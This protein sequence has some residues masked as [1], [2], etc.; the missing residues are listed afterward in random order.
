MFRIAGAGGCVTRKHFVDSP[1]IIG[2]KFEVEGS[3]ILFQILA[4]LSARNRHNV[5]T[6]REHPC[7]RQLRRLAALFLCNFLNPTH[8]IKILLKVLALET[9]GIAPV[10]VGGKI[11]EALEPSGQEAAS[12]RAVSD[13]PDTQFA[14]GG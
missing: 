7:E 5:V 1:Q 2:R 3:D 8:Q 11:V 10:I 14:A 6:L 9:R 12:Q 4:A 13:E